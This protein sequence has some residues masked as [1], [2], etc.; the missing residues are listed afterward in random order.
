M[1]RTRPGGCYLSAVR[2]ARFEIPQ[3]IFVDADGGTMPGAFD[4]GF[5]CAHREVG[6]D[7]LATVTVRPRA[8]SLGGGSRGVIEIIL[9]RRRVMLAFAAEE[10]ADVAAVFAQQRVALVFRMALKKDE[11]RISF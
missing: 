11:Q 5:E 9:R 1:P 10:A 7:A 2:A 6:D 4:A 8:K 3:P